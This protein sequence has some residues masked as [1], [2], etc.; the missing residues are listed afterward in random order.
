MPPDEQVDVVVVVDVV[1]V[2]IVG[3]GIS[4]L[5]TAWYILRTQPGLRVAVLESDPMV[6]GKIA[7]ATVAGHEVD[8]GPDAFLEIGRAHV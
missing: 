6:G 3:G 2:V 7:G 4:G 5:A 8:C 1:D